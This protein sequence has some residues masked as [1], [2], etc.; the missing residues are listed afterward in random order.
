VDVDIVEVGVLVDP[1]AGELGVLEAGVA[2]RRPWRFVLS[3]IASSSILPS[4]AASLAWA[5]WNVA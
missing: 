3:K 2:E 1:G 4:K 5:P